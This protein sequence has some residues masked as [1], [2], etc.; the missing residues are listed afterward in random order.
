MTWEQLISQ[1]RTN[2][3]SEELQ[4]EVY[5]QRKDPDGYYHYTHVDQLQRDFLD[6]Q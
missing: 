1:L 6:N 4:K 5:F 2:L 3:T